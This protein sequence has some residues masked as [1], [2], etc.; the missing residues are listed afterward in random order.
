[1]FKRI[2]WICFL[3]LFFAACVRS[4][5]NTSIPTPG[6]SIWTPGLSNVYPGESTATPAFTLLPTRIPGSQIL[7]PTP[8]LPRISA[9][10]LPGG[11]Q[12]YIV[13]YGDTLGGISTRFG[14]GLEALMLVNSLTD[15]N[16]LS[17][18]QPL[19]I[20]APTVQPPG[21][22]FKIIPDSELVYGPM[23]ITLDLESFIQGQRGYLA[24]YM[25]DVDGETLNAAQIIRRVSQNYSVNP[26]LL[27][28]LLEY[29]SG[30]VTNPNPDPATLAAPLGIRDGWHDG[31]Y[32][33]LTWT[34]NSLN[35]G[36]YLFREG[37]ITQWVLADGSVVPI[38]A[39][40][41]PGTA[42]VQYYF[43]ISAG[44]S[45]WI[46]DT[47]T[48]G[49]FATYSRLFGYPFDLAVEPLVPDVLVQPVLQLP[50]QAGEQ[51][52]FTGGPHGGW[53]AGS[54][55]AGL[56]F[57]PPGDDIGCVSS[58]AWVTAVADG[59]ILRTGNGAV[60]QDL[61]GDGYEQTGWV[62]LYMHIE[63]RD[64]VRVGAYLRAGDRIGHPSCEGGIS[65]GTHVHVARRFN[66]VWV[67]TV[68]P[69]AFVMDLWVPSTTGVEYD[70]YLTRNGV[71]VEAYAG[72][73]PI[74]L[75][76]R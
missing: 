1:M 71:I 55:W 64:R 35:R 52:A 29:R 76:Q 24:T 30:W 15:P 18:G 16:L 42:G 23:S 14:V 49:M 37:L 13:Q 47:S 10:I 57:A 34:A 20:P 19:T 6:G 11:P 68:G 36:F 2:F 60:I 48:N 8:D 12:T 54:A 72:N 51:W 25:Q 9:Q 53:D 40:I 46:L 69:T 67:E 31:L 22:G 66:G 17:V 33:Q 75:I 45:L 4:A 73:S 65:S 32:L 62:I 5:P 43:S 39:G 59:L 3:M 70:G 63:T 38:D 50:F 26:R 44:Y 41:N 74:N 58:D 56:D 28:A 21:P 27:L 7:T 61:D